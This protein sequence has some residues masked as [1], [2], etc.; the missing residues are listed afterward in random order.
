MTKVIQKI[1]WKKKKVWLFNLLACLALLKL[2]DMHSK[3]S[4]LVHRYH[5]LNGNHLFLPQKDLPHLLW[6][7]SHPLVLS[8]VT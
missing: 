6:Q 3:I 5:P 8:S 2:A 7:G 4:L 1:V